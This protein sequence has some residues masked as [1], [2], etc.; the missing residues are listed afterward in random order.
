MQLRSHPSSARQFFQEDILRSRRRIAPVLTDV[1]GITTVIV[2]DHDLLSGTE[3]EIEALIPAILTTRRRVVAA[4]MAAKVPASPTERSKSGSSL[5]KVLEQ[6]FV[7]G[8]LW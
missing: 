8:K 6:H 7:C 5:L 2:I 1:V 3:A 4:K